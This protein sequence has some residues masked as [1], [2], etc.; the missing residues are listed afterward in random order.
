MV[1]IKVVDI[2]VEVDFR[3]P[4][5]SLRLL[6]QPFLLMCSRSFHDP[7]SLSHQIQISLC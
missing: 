3:L 5:I 4:E 6:S 2:D 1:M 7:T